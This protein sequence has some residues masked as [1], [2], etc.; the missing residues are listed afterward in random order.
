MNTRVV[1]ASSARH[2]RRPSPRSYNG[3]RLPHLP[4]RRRARLLARAA[5][6]ITSASSSTR[7]SSITV[8]VN[9]SASRH[10]LVFRT[11]FASQISEPSTA[12][13]P[14]K[15]T[16]CDRESPTQPP[17][18]TSGEPENR[19]RDSHFVS[20]G[21]SVAVGLVQELRDVRVV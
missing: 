11:P 7:T 6:T 2:R 10:T 5:T 3:L 15:H 12:L 18:E 8:D 20:S 14:R 1:P 9:A 16:G 17:T 21:D 13:N 4:H 19:T